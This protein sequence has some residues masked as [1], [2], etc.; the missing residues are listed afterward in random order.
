MLLSFS[1]DQASISSRLTIPLASFLMPQK[2]VTSRVILVCFGR[3]L[4]FYPS[5][6]I[7][8]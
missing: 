8:S 7:L 2:L 6:S 1:Q 4:I 5:Y 3:E